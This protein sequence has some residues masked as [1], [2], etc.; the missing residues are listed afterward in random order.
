MAEG[1]NRRNVTI[2]GSAPGVGGLTHWRG[3]PAS[4]GGA[5]RPID[6]SPTLGPPMFDYDTDGNMREQRKWTLESMILGADEAARQA[7]ID[8]FK[9]GKVFLSTFITGIPT[10]DSTNWIIESATVT[11]HATGDSPS[12]LQ[13]VLAEMGPTSAP[14]TGTIPSQ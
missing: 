12:M 9:V 1:M 5:L 6:M 8:A 14:N 11:H 13:I 4:S 10:G 2:L 3:S 7:Y